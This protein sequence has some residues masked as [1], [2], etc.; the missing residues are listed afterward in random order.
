VNFLNG[1]L[2]L[3]ALAALVPLFIHLFNRSR[4]KIIK[5]GATH[6]LESVL[7]KNRKQVQLEQWII[8][9]I[10][11]AIPIILALTLARMVV[12]DWNSFLY[13]LILPLSALA[14]L[15]LTAF[16]TALRWP[17][18]LLSLGCVI[19]IILG[20]FGILPKWGMNKEIS[21]LSGDIP[22]STVLLLDDSLSM[23]ISGGFSNACS[24][25]SKFLANKHKQSEVSIIQMGG[26][27]ANLF[28][29]PTSD[30]NALGARVENLDALSDQA[31]LLRSLD[32][33]LSIVSQGKNLKREIILLSDFRRSDWDNWDNAAIDTFRK[34]LDTSP[35]RPELTW[36]DFGKQSKKNL[37]VE[38]IVLSSQTVGVGHPLQ[39]KATIRNLSEEKFEGNLQVQLLSED[40]QKIIDQAAIS[41]GAQATSQVTF[42]HDFNTAGPKVLHVEVLVADDLPQ[43]NR[44]SVAV[45]VIKEIEILLIDGDPSNEWL[46]GET[47]FLKIAVTPFLEVE[48]KS[49]ANTQSGGMKDL[50][51]AGVISIDQFKKPDQLDNKSL[52][53]LAN[54][55]KL[56]PLMK[57][58]LELF[59]E[60]GGGVLITAGNQMDLSWYNENWG[61]EG[62][63]F[64]PMD[65]IG[66]Q[67]A[68]QNEL[69]YSKIINSYFKH[70]ALA[71][72]NDPK[73][74][75]LSEAQI[76]K[77]AKFDE[78]K[79]R[80]DPKVTVLARLHN[81]DPLL[82]ER[83]FGKG[84]VMIFGTS[85]DTDWTNLPARPSFL[86]LVQQLATYLSEKVLPPKTVESG[87]PLT[88]YLS[89]K[90]AAFNYKI[91]LPNGSTRTLVPRKRK[92][93]YLLEFTET[94]SPGTYK[95]SSE[96][97]T[98]GKFVVQASVQESVL[99]KADEQKIIETSSVLAE[100]INRINGIKEV[101]WE[102]YERM[103]N[104]RKYGRET[105]L[106][107][108]AVVLGLI[109]MEVILLRKFGKKVP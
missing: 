57:K 61:L 38:K 21:A 76:M 70:P 65:W 31:S 25:I 106:I 96:E 68:P 77:W 19:V 91:D 67:G 54:T 98:V 108:L 11:C 12:N 14:F 29:K 24:F 59:V 64:L 88:H 10:R 35:N 94:R 80:N 34:R 75:S 93:R 81:G 3:G 27:P 87:L 58:N 4:F 28:D 62:T 20:I 8:L 33:A 52:V 105:W 13:F 84:V 78:I 109:L 39:I 102:A 100:T 26:T 40:S 83:K 97:K 53:V 41:I 9:I 74:G 85:I 2:V 60:N 103:D 50:I 42:S 6:L 66:F 104:R 37:S 55:E 36:V 92:D 16:S 51:K 63:R 7:R 46:R 90:E 69:T 82:V 107:L 18:G 101:A 71:M 1:T 56:D 45:S 79:S 30:G 43:D 23:N 17:C 95:L 5:W 15:I 89:E 72:F 99:T 47:D 32:Q 73:N 44:R 22:G 49:K 48:E 86:P